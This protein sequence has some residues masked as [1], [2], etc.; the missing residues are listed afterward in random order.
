MRSFLQDLRYAFRT[1]R[2]NPILTV[3]SLVSLGL[4]IGANTAIF[5]LMDQVLLRSL[6]VRDPERLVLLASPG[7]WS[8]FI[9]SDYNDQVVFSWPKY[10]SLA[11]GTA[12]FAGRAIRKPARILAE[13]LRAFAARHFAAGGGEPDR[14]DLACHRGG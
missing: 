14:P 2:T 11:G 1:L 8:G 10:R 3:V 7:G 4:G 9:E 13:C 5:S 6:P 12:C